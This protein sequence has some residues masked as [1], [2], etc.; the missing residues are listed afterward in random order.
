MESWRG[1][2]RRAGRDALVW[3]AGAWR[4]GSAAGALLEGGRAAPGGDGHHGARDTGQHA[5]DDEREDDRERVQP[6]SSGAAR[7]PAGR[8]PVA[9]PAL[10]AL[11]S[12]TG[13]S[14]PARRPRHDSI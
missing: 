9:G 2:G 12:Q 10:Q 1:R 5:S 7:P 14:P 8:A 3:L 6:V 13:A 4:A 11:A